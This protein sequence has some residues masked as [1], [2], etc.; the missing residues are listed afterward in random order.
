[1]N[2]QPKPTA[3]SPDEGHSTVRQSQKIKPFDVRK[4]FTMMHNAVLDFIMPAL[5]GSEWK[6]LCYIIRHTTGFGQPSDQIS[7]TQIAR[8]KFSP[9]GKRQ[10]DA[11]AGVK[12]AATISEAVKT[13]VER[14]Y[15]FKRLGE[16]WD[17][18]TYTLNLEF[19]IEGSPAPASI[20]E[21]ESNSIIEAPLL[22]KSKQQTGASTFNY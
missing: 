9:D 19:E 8:G 2:K 22:Q 4:N 7:Y 5:S 13:L 1:M 16:K 10:L 17:A 6:I 12:S 15:V 18:T 3:V 21:A 11:G 20:I 14:G